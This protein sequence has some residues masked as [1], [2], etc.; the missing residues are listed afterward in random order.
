M[1]QWLN[2]KEIEVVVDPN[3]NP[4]ISA[5]KWLQR[6]VFIDL[7]EILFVDFPNIL[8]EWI[9]RLLEQNE[10]FHTFVLKN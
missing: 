1:G 4:R 6:Y 8:V 9:Q 7:H 2:T 5:E 10:R 3:K